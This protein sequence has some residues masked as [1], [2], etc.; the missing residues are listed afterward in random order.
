MKAVE[1]A[2][3]VYE[4]YQN[5]E[6]WVSKSELA[7]ALNLLCVECLENVAVKR[8]VVCAANQLREDVLLTGV[9]H[10]DSLMR[11][12]WTNLPDDCQVNKHSCEQGFIDQHGVFMSR[13]EAWKVA[14]AAGQI[15]RRV[16]G[17]E[18]GTLYS[19]NLY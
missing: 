1:N 5:Q 9:R 16:G 17:D 12:Q 10:W 18:S 11:K 3:R 13:T 8:R 7:R 15:I 14:L 2:Q 6:E 4:A 19:E